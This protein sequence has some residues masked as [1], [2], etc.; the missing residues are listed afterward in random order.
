MLDASLLESLTRPE[1]RAGDLAQWL[2]SDVWTE[3]A[4]EAAGRD[5][6]A[7]LVAGERR[8]H[9][10]EIL[11]TRCAPSY[12]DEL[13]KAPGPERTVAGFFERHPNGAVTLFDGASLR[14][15]PR[16]LQ[17]A[18]ASR[19][20]VLEVGAGRSAVPSETI[21]FVADRLGLGLPAIGPSQLESRQELKERG[22]AFHYF[23]SPS[24]RPPIR[25]TT[26]RLLLWSRFPDLKYS[27][28]DASGPGLFSD[29]WKLFEPVWR[30][31]VQAVPPDRP[32]LVTSDHGYVFLGGA[33]SDR[34]LDGADRVLHRKR[35][36]Q[37]PL[38]E[39]LPAARPGIWLDLDRR[40]G[41]L[42]GR[43]QNRPQGATGA[44]SLYRHGGLSLM[45]VFTPW[46]VLGPVVYGKGETE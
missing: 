27:D 12:L 19:R 23:R 18:R 35:Y 30:E 31:T 38:D 10:R 20:T 6:A 13:V 16:L 43:C 40:I 34:D 44:Q 22:I 24:H 28:S 8:V 1:W 14:E 39:P 41:V 4:F 33:L 25:Q 5:P 15:V 21:F 26:D 37:F 17:L 11:L 45:E 36:Y 32:V 3:A 7:Y 46:I 9:E 42:A 2:I 29:V